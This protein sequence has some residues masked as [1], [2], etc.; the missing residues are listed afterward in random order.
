MVACYK[1]DLRDNVREE[2][3]E[4]FDK[5][6]G[7]IFEDPVAETSQAGKFKKEYQF[8]WGLFSNV[9]TYALGDAKG[10]DK[11]SVVRI[12]SIPR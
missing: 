5:I 6:S 2:L 12:R 8:K 7:D 3:L 4:E 9:K 11:A 10:E 1:P